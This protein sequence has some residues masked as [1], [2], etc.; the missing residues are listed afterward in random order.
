MTQSSKQTDPSDGQ[1]DGPF[2]G[3][4]IGP[5]LILDDLRDG[6]MHLAVLVLARGDAVP[7]PIETATGQHPLTRLVDY[8]DL[9][10]WR[11]RFAV[12]AD[13]ASAYTWQGQSYPLASDLTGDMRLAYVSCNGEEH[14]DLDRDP[15]ERNVM[16]RRLA[17]A[18]DTAPASL[19]LHGGDQIYADEVTDDHPL[20]AGW[21]QDL[22]K[23]PDTGAVSEMRARLRVGFAQRYA[24]LYAQP[25]FA[26]MA[27]RVPSLMQ[28]DDHDIC[29]GWGSLPPEA[30]HSEVGQTLFSVA[31]EAALVFQHGCVD[32]DLPARFDD[33]AGAHLGWQVGTD[34]LRLVAPDLRSQRAFTEVMGESGW[35]FMADVSTA[36][37][38]LQTFLMS[39]V[40]LLGPRLSLI[41]RLMRRV[42]GIQKYEDDLRDQWQS[43]V[44]RRSW[45][46]ML[47]LVRRIK[48]QE[49]AQVT[50]LS[51]EIHLAARAEMQLGAG[52]RLHQLVASGITHRAPPQAWARALGALASLGEDPLPDTQIHMLPLPGQRHRYTAERNALILLRE[53]GAWNAVWRLEQSGDT[54]PLALTDG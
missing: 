29:D 2:I 9:T 33:P 38:P 24:Q 14:G 20:S 32:G 44:H 26:F 28:W 22:P 42:P 50:A 41:E 40:P 16:W 4:F 36:P 39:S 11:A 43:R 31:R 37:A 35:A 52:K 1:L 48:Q 34:D 47:E 5:V 15:A 6:Q 46:R 10:V 17:E 12:P 45:I 7:D 53:E 13:R 18:Q 49:G 21:P 54:P 3:P 27:A 23:A 30:T 8:A 25:E 51:G 19:L